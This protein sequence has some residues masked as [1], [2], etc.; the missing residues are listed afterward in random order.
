[1]LACING[2]L[3]NCS[4]V[5]APALLYYMPSMALCVALLYAI[6]PTIGVNLAACYL[7]FVTRRYK[8]ENENKAG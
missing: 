7:I 4:S 8:Q 3:G 5:T 6:R 2:G 1:M